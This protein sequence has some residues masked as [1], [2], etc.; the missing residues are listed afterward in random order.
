[1][2]KILKS[3]VFKNPNFIY[4]TNAF[5][6]RLYDRVYEN[7]HRTEHKSWGEFEKEYNLQIIKKFDNR[8]KYQYDGDNSYIGF[9]FFKDRTDKRHIEINFAGTNKRYLP[10]TLLILE[11][12]HTIEFSK[13]ESIMPDKP[14]LVYELGAKMLE[15]IR[16]CF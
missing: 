15:Q 6:L 5:D 3:H 16:N 11:K 4:K 13:P 12:S 7:W 8:E 9:I 1:M 14:F 2:I 10:N